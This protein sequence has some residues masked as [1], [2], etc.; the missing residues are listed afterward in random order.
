MVWFTLLL[1]LI[2]LVSTV[3]IQIPIQ[4]QLAKGFSLELIDKLISTDMIYRKI[5]MI[6]MAIINFVMLHKVVENS[7]RRID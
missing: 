3:T 2:A 6:L 1:N 7:N 4:N 5:P